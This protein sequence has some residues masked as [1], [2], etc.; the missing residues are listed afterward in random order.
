MS[1]IHFMFS[2]QRVFYHQLWAHGVT[3]SSFYMF[4]V[5]DTCVP[6]DLLTSKDREVRTGA[7]YRILVRDS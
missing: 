5:R 6:S 4:F 2:F 1:D 7:R 3:A